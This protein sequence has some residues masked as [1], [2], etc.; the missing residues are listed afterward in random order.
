MII[1]SVLVVALLIVL[2]AIVLLSLKSTRKENSG[3]GY[4]FAAGTESE[5]MSDCPL[6]GEPLRKGEQVH[7]LLFPGEDDGIMH[8]YGCPYC[9]IGHPRRNSSPLKTRVCPSCRSV[10]GAKDY[11]YARV[12]RKPYKTHVSV[13]GCTLCRGIRP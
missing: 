1:L 5:K 12:F 6:C 10:L 2:A 11:V 3:T 4:F 13:V 8:I 7:S 9:Y